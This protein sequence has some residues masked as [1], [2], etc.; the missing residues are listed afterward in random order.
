MQKKRIGLFTIIILLLLILS[1]ST[2]VPFTKSVIKD[3]KLSSEDIEHLQFYLSDYLILEREI[4]DIDKTLT[5]SHSLKKV[6]DK[7]ID[8]IIIKKGTPCIVT[9]IS[10]DTLYVA[11][12]PNENLIFCSTLKNNNLF[13]LQLNKKLNSKRHFNIQGEDGTIEVALNGEVLYQ[14]NIYQVFT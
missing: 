2:N 9:K 7:F 6:K 11:F 4:E 12:E 10:N 13:S 3:Y 5:K 1:C 8:Q 14:N